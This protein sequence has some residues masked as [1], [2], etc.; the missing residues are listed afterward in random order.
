MNVKR[1]FL[2]AAT[3]ASMLCA[4]MVVA[5]VS[6]Q[7]PR[8]GDTG[9][10]PIPT[11]CFLKI[12][13]V[14]GEATG[15]MIEVLSWSWGA[16]N[17]GTSGLGGGGGA[18]KASF[19]DFHFTKTLDKSSPKLFLGSATGEHFPKAVLRCRKAGS[20]SQEYLK[21]TLSD[22]MVTSYQS[23]GTGAAA[24]AEQMSLN[25]A[26]IEFE[27]KPQKADGSLD[28]PVKAGYDLKANKKI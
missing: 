28:A 14:E 18:G 11:G 6:A 1:K 16:S 13:G 7:T 22:V 4:A 20:N 23:G 19:K 21:Y 8:A 3:A 25:Y 10:A 5:G 2:T 12:D 26:K 17:M 27:Y 9:G 15:G 24:P